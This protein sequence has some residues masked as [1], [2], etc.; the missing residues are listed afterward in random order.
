M[1]ASLS[2]FVPVHNE[3]A[4]IGSLVSHLLEVLP[5][6][7]PRFEL[8]VIDDGSSDATPEVIHEVVEPYP[9]VHAIVHPARWGAAAAMRSGLSH[10][11]GEAILFRAEHNRLGLGCLPQLWS[12]IGGRD[13]VLARCAADVHLGAI[14]ELPGN[15]ANDYGWQLVRR[16]L[17]DA[18]RRDADD[19]DWL[20]YVLSRGKR[21][22]ELEFRPQSALSAAAA[23][24]PPRS[25]WA[26]VLSAAA[27]GASPSS[28][29]RP[30]YLSRLKAF[31]MGE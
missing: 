14:P 7:T 24:V 1:K 28:A 29:K 31:A 3:Q 20:G 25:A 18:W 23:A 17:L 19:E 2:V 26:S 10:S 30:N 13:A 27:H 6:L 15:A 11:S 16:T 22:A 4:G 8:V 9:Q 5:E 12:A 21:V